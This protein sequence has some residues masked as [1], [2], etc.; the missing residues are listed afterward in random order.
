MKDKGKGIAQKFYDRV[1][2]TFQTL[3]ARDKVEN[4]G[5][6]LLGLHDCDPRILIFSRFYLRLWDRTLLWVDRFLHLQCKYIN[7]TTFMALEGKM[8]TI[9]LVDDDEMD[10]T[11]AQRAFKKNNIL[12]PL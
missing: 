11:N 5:I 10:V 1:F 2:T 8:L 4:I 9:V 3:A 12:D 7:I 6:D